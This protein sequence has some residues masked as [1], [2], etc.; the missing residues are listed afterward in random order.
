MSQKINWEKIQEWQNEHPDL[1]IMVASP[2]EDAM[3]I[4]FAKLNTFV[5]FP[6][7][8]MEKGVIF[9]ALRKSKF[10]V[11]IDPFMTGLMTATGLSEKDEGG[12]V[13]KVLGGSMKGIGEQRAVLSAS[14][15]INAKTNKSKNR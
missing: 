6:G 8:D 12:E 14:K 11:A 9:N 5:K 15:K 4:S 2:R 10:E 13:L 1:L 7:A 3:S